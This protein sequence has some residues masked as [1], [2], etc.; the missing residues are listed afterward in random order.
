M[1]GTLTAGTVYAML[2]FRSTRARLPH[3]LAFY[4]GLG[5]L[6]VALASPLD[7]LGGCCL[8]S[9]H[10]GQHILL[11]TLAPPALVWGLKGALRRRP[12]DRPWA[13]AAATGALVANTYLWHLPGAYQLALRS[14]PVHEAEHLLYLA[15]G[16]AYWWTVISRPAGAA[17]A[18]VEWAVPRLAALLGAALGMMP[19]GLVLLWAGAPLYPFY[20]AG[21]QAVGW[22]P[23]LDQQVAAM[24]MLMSGGAALSGGLCAGFLLLTRQQ[25]TPAGVGGAGGT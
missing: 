25:T 2:A 13:L 23:L 10:M 15:T 21:A 8:L 17:G 9:A 3:A 11:L 1:I 7:R 20:L 16:L 24:V 22:P 18:W 5:L 19:L 12:P 14:G 4:A 6:V